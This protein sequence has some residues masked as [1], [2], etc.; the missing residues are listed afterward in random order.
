M[1]APTSKLYLEAPR[2]LRALVRARES[3]LIVLAAIVG[4]LGG[5]FVVLMSRAVGLLHEVLFNIPHGERLS[6]Q[7][8]LEPMRAV[9]MPT[10]GGLLFGLSL[11]A[12]HR[13]RPGREVDPIEANAL[14]GGKMSFRGSIIVAL[15]T[16]WSSGVGASVGTEAGYTQISSG[17][18]SVLGQAFHL[19][20][21]DQRILVGCGSAAAIAGA[22]GAPL[23][24]AFYAFELIVSGYTPASLAPIGVASITGYA[25]AHQLAPTVPGI[26]LSQV[27]TVTS[28]DIVIAVALGFLC[29]LAGIAVMR[30][31]AVWDTVMSRSRLWLPLRPTIGGL[32]M[33][34]FALQAPQVMSSGHGALHTTNVV[35]LP[36]L[37]VAFLFA[38]K[39]LASVISLGSGFRGG[40]FFSSL[41]S[42]AL[43]GHLFAAAMNTLVPSLHL[44]ISV[45]A[46]IGMSALSAAV[47]GGPLTMTFIA[48]ETTGN[49]WLTTAVLIAVI[50]STQV[51]RELFGYSFATWRFHLRGETIRSAADIGWIRDLTVGRMMRSDVTTVPVE[52]PIDT[53]RQSYPLGSKT[54]VIA[55]DSEQKYAGIVFV[56]DAYASLDTPADTVGD[57]IR[58]QDACL[59]PD[60]N[61]QDAVA[62]FD[63]A[64]AESLAVIDKAD[65]RRVIGILTEAHALRR[66]AEETDRH[67]RHSIGEA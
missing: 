23:A 49:L 29:A 59:L 50:V 15:Q 9:I 46:V 10:L 25:V 62:A 20:R 2:R 63:R 31:V 21:S 37:M 42:G 4:I 13:W 51:T 27:G 5:L 67:R 43:G 7:S 22:F 41:L 12:L 45:Y 26:I 39:I 1:T 55:V 56:A 34:L 53:F 14:H 19:R 24:G 6:S 18:A 61:A 54:Q 28:Q 60:M 16:I 57:I 40:L 8:V 36:V 33:G 44:D 48:L 32:V 58:Y 30:A 17:T 52:M 64:E 65:T 11:L 3:S 35:T 47:V 38:L 66:Y